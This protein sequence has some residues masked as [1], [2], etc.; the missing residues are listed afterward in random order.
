MSAIESVAVS[1]AHNWVQLKFRHRITLTHMNVHRFERISFV[2]VK[3]KPIALIA[4]YNRH[5]VHAV[6]VTWIA[7]ATKS[8]DVIL[9]DYAMRQTASESEHAFG[10]H[11]AWLQDLR[12][13]HAIGV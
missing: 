2:R 12:Q 8:T 3:E 1:H 6:Y 10:A 9:A 7:M 5:V 13:K 4:K 11:M